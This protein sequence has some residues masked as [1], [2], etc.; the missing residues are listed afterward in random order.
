MASIQ[1][2]FVGAVTRLAQEAG[3]RCP[4][5]DQKG[6]KQAVLE[7]ARR[8]GVSEEILLRSAAEALGLP[9]VEDLTAEKASTRF[10]EKIPISFAR[11]YGVLGLS[12]SNGRLPVV[13]GNM[14]AWPELEVLSRFL[15]CPI[16]PM[17][18]RPSEVASAINHAYQQRNGQ[19]E[20]VIQQLDRH[21]VL[22]QVE[23]LHSRED[24]LDVASRAPVIKLVHMILFEAVKQLASDVHIQP[25]EDKLVVR[26][27][28]DGMLID[29]HALP[30]EIQDEVISRIKIMGRMNIAEK[31]LAQDGRTTVQVGDRMIDL[32]IASIPASFGERIVIRLLDK[33][34]ELYTLSRLGMEQATLERFR[35]LIAAEH[36]L[37]L[38]TGPT[39]SGK[40]TTL[41]ATLKELN[42]KERNILTLEDPIEYELPG[43]S[44]TQVSD[45]KGMTFASGLRSVLR[46]DP[47]IIM[48]G[49]IRD[50]E[51]AVMAIQSA[52]TGHLV[53]STL[54][55]N[56]AAS[57]VT[58]LLDLG[59]E[60]Y[61]VASSVVGVMAQRLVRQVCIDCGGAF[62]PSGDALA[63][64]GIDPPRDVDTASLMR[65][66][67]CEA[68]RQTGY[69]GRIG[70]FELLVVDESIRQLIQSRATASQI[71]TAAVS[72]GMKTL[73]QDA[74]T[75][76][77]QG[78]TSIDE[79]A[80]LTTRTVN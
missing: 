16:K 27:R 25:Y 21:E 77:H 37:I 17:I 7:V 50:H 38:V 40:S 33:T 47:D 74:I 75:K 14:E 76:M 35:P 34:A 78:I 11:Q 63:K 65:G 62:T 20:E 5:D 42:R 22:A 66:A 39:G 23:Q 1:E 69:R 12:S 70:V 30:K 59:I 13:M 8:A 71:K 61:L 79:V 46:Q 49:E 54:H 18:A 6:A 36:G 43:I 31:R 15:G 9:Y 80:R 67:G 58:R 24:L 55:T 68:C 60:P 3:V 19:A 28:I 73:A 32:R 41:Y 53:F 4:V 45:K 56:D 52:L 29:A 2:K 44:Q 57:A 26:M 72:G 64:L 51:T 10:V 48:V